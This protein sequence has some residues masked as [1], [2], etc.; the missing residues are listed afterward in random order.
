MVVCE[1]NARLRRASKLTNLTGHLRVSAHHKEDVMDFLEE[2]DDGLEDILGDKWV[3][4]CD[5]VLPCK[6]FIT[7]HTI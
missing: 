7:A 2:L 5:G 3:G 1:Y 4:W 6:Y